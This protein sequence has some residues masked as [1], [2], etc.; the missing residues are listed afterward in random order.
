[1][2][3]CE[4]KVGIKNDK[5]I[6]Y[7][8]SVCKSKNVIEVSL[9]D[10]VDKIDMETIKTDYKLTGRVQYNNN[11]Y[12]NLIFNKMEILKFNDAVSRYLKCLTGQFIV[13]C[14]LPLIK[15]KSNEGIKIIFAENA[16]K[17]RYDVVGFKFISKPKTTNYRRS[18]R[19]V[20]TNDP[21][22]Q[23]VNSIKAGKRNTNKIRRISS[24]IDVTFDVQKNK[25]I[26]KNEKGIIKHG[27]GV[28]TAPPRKNAQDVGAS[29]AAP[30]KKADIEK[31]NI[32][33]KSKKIKTRQK[34]SLT[35]IKY[36]IYYNNIT[37][38]LKVIANVMAELSQSRLI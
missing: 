37:E 4:S 3:Q 2:Q 30:S 5:T 8:S 21:S 33:I 13:G 12:T 7:L 11:L 36:G 26:R 6:K 15:Q 14:N 18:K 25:D 31:I 20:K 19:S 1:M 22:I 10:N 17:L 28:V 38:S 35:W 24:F 34:R 32:H 23:A 29:T 9:T 16:D 27:F